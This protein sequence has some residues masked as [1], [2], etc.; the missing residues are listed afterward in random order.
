MNPPYQQELRSGK[1]TE[2][3]PRACVRSVIRKAGP[4]QL[5]SKHPDSDKRSHADHGAEAGDFKLADAEE[6]WVH[7]CDYRYGPVKGRA[8]LARLGSRSIPY[9]SCVS[10]QTLD[11]IADLRGRR[12]D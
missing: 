1:A 10:I 5:A 12:K 4:A 9:L 6:Q 2:H 3:A 11:V 7:E 8:V